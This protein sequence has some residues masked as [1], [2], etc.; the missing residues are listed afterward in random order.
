MS[1]TTRTG[2]K[3]PGYAEPLDIDAYNKANITEKQRRAAAVRKALDKKLHELEC[4][5]INQRYS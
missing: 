4:K 5:K 3:A 1:K 2:I